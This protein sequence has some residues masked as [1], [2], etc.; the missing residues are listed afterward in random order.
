VQAGGTLL[1]LSPLA[2]PAT[3]PLLEAVEDDQGSTVASIL[4]VAV[5]VLVIAGGLW[6]VI[7]AVRTITQRQAGRSELE[8]ESLWSDQNLVADL[9]NSLLE[10]WNRIRALAD[11]FRGRRHR[12]AATVR[13]IYA[14][15]VDLAAEAGYPRGKAVTPYEYR[16]TLHQVFAGGELAADA[17][18]EA[19]VRVHYGEV[20]DTQAEMD[21]L[22][23]HWQLIQT[24]AAPP[25]AEPQA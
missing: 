4:R 10:G 14:S 21:Q 22:R 18:T 13:K 2:S 8:R 9:K 23:Q 17:I 1:N 5:I 19:Y 25:P 11:P 20:P 3:N 24:L 7:R 16:E 6:L 12:S 15:M